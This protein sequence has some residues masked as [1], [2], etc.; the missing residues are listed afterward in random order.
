[1]L[2]LNLLPHVDFDADTELFPVSD[3]SEPY[4]ANRLLLE[5]DYVVTDFGNLSALV[6][7]ALTAGVAAK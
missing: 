4:S 5:A 6:A 2:T 7:E 3:F 1:M